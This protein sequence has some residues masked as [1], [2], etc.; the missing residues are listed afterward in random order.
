MGAPVPPPLW[1]WVLSGSGWVVALLMAGI[2]WIS[3]RRDSG[4]SREDALYQPDP[5]NLRQALVEVRRCA[6]QNDP[7]AIRRAVL[8][9]AYLHHSRRFATFTELARAS[10]EDLAKRLIA[11]DRCLYGEG[12]ISAAKQGLVEALREEPAPRHHADRANTL[13]LYPT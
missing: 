11:L 12:D 7:A 10:S 1:I 3:R 4:T 9:W 13:A 8:A 2:M 6:E 5:G